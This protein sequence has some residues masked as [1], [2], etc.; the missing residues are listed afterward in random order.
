MFTLEGHTG[1]VFCLAYSPDGSALASGD[2]TGE[3]I[4]WDVAARKAR[5]RFHQPGAYEKYQAKHVTSV[6]FSP[7]G[8]MLA[9]TT[10]SHPPF[11]RVW[12][13]SDLALLC[14]W[15]GGWSANAAVFLPD[16]RTVVS[17]GGVD[18]HECPLFRWQVP[19]SPPVVTRKLD[20]DPRTRQPDFTMTGHSKD[21]FSLACSPAGDVL[22]GSADGTAR[23]WDVE[24]RRE[25]R[26]RNFR[27]WVRC[28]AL[29]PD[30]Q[31]AAVAAGKFVHLWGL[32]G[33]RRAPRRLAGH[34]DR[35][36]AVAFHPDGALVGSGGRDGA[37]RLWDVAGGAERQ[38]L[39]FRVWWVGAL[40]FA[41]GGGTAAVGGGSGDV[42]V[43][44][45][46]P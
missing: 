4:V 7:D 37:V 43:F 35:V 38:A 5:Q 24:G 2:G 11:T 32:G 31:T 28:V 29:S 26:S 19:E 14:E 23:L 34:S 10:G 17:A 25:V 1:G 16:G 44:D 22:S 9:T 45:V 18:A 3:L 8:S 15:E 41:P 30:G 40:A 33:D 39:S 27:A 6:E 36:E 21:V 20:G 12:R 46:D 13:A 42:V